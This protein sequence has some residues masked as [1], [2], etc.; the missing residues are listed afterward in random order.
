MAKRKSN[1]KQRQTPQRPQPGPRPQPTPSGL[2]ATYLPLATYVRLAERLA[3]ERTRERWRHTPGANQAELDA[4]RELHAAALD[5][6]SNF[7]REIDEWLYAHNQ[8]RWSEM[9]WPEQDRTLMRWM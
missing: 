3:A 8:P 9:S 7:A 2:P 5:V 4:E 1:T 6:R